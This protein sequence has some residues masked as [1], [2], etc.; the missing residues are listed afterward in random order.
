MTELEKM[1]KNTL[2]RMEQEFSAKLTSQDKILAEQQRALTVH[3]QSLCQLQKENSQIN[4]DLQA[5]AQRL[6]DLAGLYK[7]LESLLL[8]LNGLL[9]VR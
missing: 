3:N 7:T 9:N 1:L 8:R 4:A 6:E 2:I 5:L